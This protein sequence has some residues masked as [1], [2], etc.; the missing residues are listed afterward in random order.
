[1]HN[2]LVKFKSLLLVMLL[3]VSFGGCYETDS[4]SNGDVNGEIIA[5]DFGADGYMA[6][7]YI[8]EALKDY[9]KFSYENHS[10]NGVYGNNIEGTASN[11]DL[12]NK[13]IEQCN[14]YF[15]CRIVYLLQQAHS[16][17][18]SYHITEASNGRTYTLYDWALYFYYPDCINNS[19]IKKIY[20]DNHVNSPSESTSTNPSIETLIFTDFNGDGATDIS[21]KNGIDKFLY[22][23]YSG[24]G[25]SI[26]WWEGT[27]VP[28]IQSIND[29]KFGDFN[30]DGKGD[31]AQIFGGNKLYIHYLNANGLF[32]L[33]EV[34]LPIYG[35]LND[36]IV[37][38]FNHDGKTDM[39][40]KN[41]VDNNLYISYATENGMNSWMNTG[42]YVYGTINDMK[43]ADF[44]G[45]GHTDMAFKNTIDHNLYISYATDSG[46]N[47]W[48][49]TGVTLYCSINEVRF[50]DFN[51]DNKVDMAFE[52]ENH[53]LYIAYST[54]TGMNWWSETGLYIYGT[55][56]DLRFGDFNGDGNTD[57]AFKN[58]TNNKLYI[59][60]AS[61]TGMN[62]WIET[63]VIIYGSV[64]DL[65][66]GDFNGD[67]KTDAAF[68]YINNYLY[69]AYGTQTGMNPWAETGIRV[70]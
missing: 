70:Y 30:G 37:A 26:E 12:Y 4:F 7:L 31:V 19:E 39:A 48:I 3:L 65:R 46:M 54:A 2:F 6:Y 62:W 14:Y 42:V 15:Y 40:F 61:N 20:W 24:I 66:F 67:G 28:V 63:D 9:L 58:V 21:F 43:F 50:E 29:L 35:T 25:G 69:I 36:I 8:N 5:R 47:P 55:M 68:K 34:G 49:N 41:V 44:N 52:H 17:A 1:M 53:Y 33:V 27:S 16:E 13:S 18:Y 22:I 32:Q 45:D 57:L 38:D 10:K 60:L 64:N 11:Y 56:N 59:A 51:G 23:A